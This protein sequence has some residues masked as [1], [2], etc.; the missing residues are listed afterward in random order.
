MGLSCGGCLASRSEKVALLIWPVDLT[1][2]ESWI[3]FLGLYWFRM[4]SL[5]A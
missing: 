2:G 3:P 4:R 1:S 5:R